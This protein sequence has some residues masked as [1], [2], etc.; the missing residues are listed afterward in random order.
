MHS[1]RYRYMYVEFD[2]GV[3]VYKSAEITRFIPK[4]YLRDPRNKPSIE[5]I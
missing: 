4:D 5:K 3:Y 2:S 1:Q